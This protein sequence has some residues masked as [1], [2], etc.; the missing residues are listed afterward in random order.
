VVAQVDAGEIDAEVQESRRRERGRSRWRRF[1]PLFLISSYAALPVRDAVVIALPMLNTVAPAA[2]SSRP[3]HFTAPFRLLDRAT[4]SAR[5]T[6]FF[7]EGIPVFDDHTGTPSACMFIARDGDRDRSLRV[8]TTG[9]TIV[10]SFHSL[11]TERSSRLAIDRLSAPSATSTATSQSDSGV[12]SPRA[13]DPKMSMPLRSSPTLAAIKARM[14][15]RVA[16]SAPSEGRRS[17]REFVVIGLPF[18]LG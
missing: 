10:P 18:R 4:R 1:M 16:A 15:R 17:P 11:T 3:L 6:A 13:L 12:A 8:R 7:D 2:F 14:R 5:Q 9:L